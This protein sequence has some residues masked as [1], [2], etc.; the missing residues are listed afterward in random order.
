MLKGLE[1]DVE[2]VQRRSITLDLAIIVKT[3]PV[4]LR[5]AGR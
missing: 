2:Y 4:L 5:G 1:L 3:I